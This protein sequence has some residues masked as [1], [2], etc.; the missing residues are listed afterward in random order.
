M[1]VIDLSSAEATANLRT[2]GARWP[3]G[4]IVQLGPFVKPTIKPSFTFSRS[5]RI[6]TMGSCFARNLERR[7]VSLGFDAPMTRYRIDEGGDR[8][9]DAGVMNKYT[10]HSMANELAWAVAEPGVHANREG[11]PVPLEQL[12]L[13][14]EDGTWEDLHLH[15][16]GTPSTFDQVKAR[17]IETEKF[18]RELKSCNVFI[19]TLGLVES[20]FDTETGLHLNRAPPAPSLRK[21]P[22]RYRLHVLTHDEI[23][24]QLEFMYSLLAAHAPPGF[25]VLI[26]VSPVPFRAT[27]S[28]QDATVANTYGKSAQRAAVELFVAH[29]A[30]VDYFPSYEIATLSDR[31]EVREF[32]NIHVTAHAVEQIMDHVIAAY[33]PDVDVRNAKSDT[34]GS[35]N[36]LTWRQQAA[37]AKGLYRD[38]EY[39]KAALATSGVLSLYREQMSGDQRA[40]FQSLLGWSLIKSDQREAARSFLATVDPGT[41]S[42]QAAYQIGLQFSELR[43][44]DQSLACFERARQSGFD[45]PNLSTLIDRAATNRGKHQAAP[46]A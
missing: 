45:A 16:E 43:M 3:D 38:Q 36:K 40:T 18:T 30:N 31:N 27:F 39:G 8:P 46:S 37:F 4:R 34:S 23:L 5:D 25:R 21:S 28:G 32:D 41:L 35:R 13:Q 29:H 42:G 44:V 9:L 22:S 10:V 17:R 20:W 24:E 11:R 15:V 33:A 19:F 1:P 14:L 12:F 6:F 26:T 7:L 2:K